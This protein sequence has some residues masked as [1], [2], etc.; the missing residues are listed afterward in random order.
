MALEA[1]TADDANPKGYH[2]LAMA[3]ER[4]GHVHKALV[5]YERALEL[6]PNDPELLIN[7]GLTAWNL[8]IREGAAQLFRL[9]I[10]ACPDSPLGYNSLGSVQSDMGDTNTAIATLSDAIRRMPQE[11]ILWNS[12]AT[13]LAEEGKAEESLVFYHEATRLAPDFARL[14]HN[15]GYAYSHLGQLEDALAAYDKALAYASDPAEILESR[16]SR[17]ICLIGMGRL[18]EGFAE[19][20]IR[21]DV[22]FRSFVNH[23]LKAPLWQGEELEGKRILII[24]EQGL[25]DELMF[26]GHP[27]R[28]PTRRGA[29]GQAADRGRS[30]PGDAVPALLS[31]CRCRQ[32]QRPHLARQGRQQTAA[33][34]AV[35]ERHGRARFHAPMG[36]TLHILRKRLEDFPHR[37]FLVP[38][39]ERV[40]H[41]RAQLAA[42]GL[43]SASA[44][45]R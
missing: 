39:P 2:V 33:L 37:A 25:G 28:H 32:L 26:R 3:L 36:S 14:Y 20:E 11:P 12:L 29:A 7:L 43:M 44:G 9:Y 42:P 13:V 17:S 41:F 22:R 5:T 18:E 40:E 23:L 38:D 6:D 30:A 4:M 16:H 8:K 31:R 34:G 19:Y 27:A 24:G 21:N 10:A 1:V 15:L 35:P 45:V